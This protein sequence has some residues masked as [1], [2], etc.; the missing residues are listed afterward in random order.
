MR[1]CS[2]RFSRLLSFPSKQLCIKTSSKIHTGQHK[3]SQL[4]LRDPNQI[5]SCITWLLKKKSFSNFS[6]LCQPI[7]FPLKQKNAINPWIIGY[8]KLIAILTADYRKNTVILLIF[9]AIFQTMIIFCK[10]TK[11]LLLC[12]HLSWWEDT[13]YTEQESWHSYSCQLVGLLNFPP[14]IH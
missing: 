3:I 4:H 8:F 7:P 2:S 10:H 12:T 6:D 11:Q 13:A 9:V 14:Y 5:L 1:Y